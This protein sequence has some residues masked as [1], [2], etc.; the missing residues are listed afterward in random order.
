MGYLI[1]C[2]HSVAT[3]CHSIAA[4]TIFLVINYIIGKLDIQQEQR[5]CCF[6]LNLTVGIHALQGTMPTVYQPV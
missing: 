6:G 5:Q 3:K 4:P 1:F 2:C